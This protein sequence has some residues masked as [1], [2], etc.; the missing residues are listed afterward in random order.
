MALKVMNKKI[1]KKLKYRKLQCF[2][3]TM[4]K[5]FFK[6]NFRKNLKSNEHHFILQILLQ[7]KKDSQQSNLQVLVYAWLSGLFF[8]R[9]TGVEPATLSLGSW[10]SAT[11]LL[12]HYF[13][14]PSVCDPGTSGLLLSY[15]IIPPVKIRMYTIVLQHFSTDGWSQKHMFFKSKEQK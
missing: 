1:W 5:N 11:E 2:L 6:K 15:S 14:P 8:E 10:C 3:I 9:E 4:R 7:I 13:L 12:P